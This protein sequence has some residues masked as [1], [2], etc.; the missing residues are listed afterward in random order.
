[1]KFTSHFYSNE[2]FP[3]WTW[4]EATQGNA[5]LKI[6]SFKAK[7]SFDF[8]PLSVFTACAICL[9]SGFFFFSSQAGTFP[10]TRPQ[11]EGEGSFS[12][13]SN[14]AIFHFPKLFPHAIYSRWYRSSLVLFP[15]FKKEMCNYKAFIFPAPL[16]SAFFCLLRGTGNLQ[17]CPHPLLSRP[18]HR[19]RQPPAVPH[20]SRQ[21]LVLDLI[22]SRCCSLIPLISVCNCTTYYVCVT[23]L[24]RHRP[25]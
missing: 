7:V 1:M 23:V 25:Y 22:S 21:N 24:A 6:N 8:V 18:V 20:F 2:I 3:V 19:F 5:N 17:L 14:T 11:L 9:L 10:V 12:T 4:A 15:S 16:P 13:L